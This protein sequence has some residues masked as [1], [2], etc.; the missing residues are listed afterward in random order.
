MSFKNPT[1]WKGLDEPAIQAKLRELF[2]DADALEDEVYL[3]RRE[4][5]PLGAVLQASTPD[6]KGFR[7]EN[8]EAYLFM[9]A[10]GQL[11]M[12]NTVGE[13]LTEEKVSLV[14]LGRDAEGSLLY[15]FPE[16]VTDEYGISLLAIVK[17]YL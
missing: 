11:T 1:A 15:A 9:G 12:T 14:Q 8:P 17:L 16:I 2:P 13:S 7:V 4:S 10:E 6:S 3:S 5:A